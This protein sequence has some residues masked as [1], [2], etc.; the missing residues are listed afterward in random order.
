MEALRP[1]R[2]KEAY[3]IE[4]GLSGATHLLLIRIQ[5]DDLGRERVICA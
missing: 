4:Q 5:A 3:G 2:G 1:V